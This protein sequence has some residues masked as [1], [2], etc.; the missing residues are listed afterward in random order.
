MCKFKSADAIFEYE[1]DTVKLV[2]GI[3]E[4]SHTEI[5][6]K[7]HIAEVVGNGEPKHT[8]VEYYPT[9]AMDD[10]GDYKFVFDDSRPN[11]WTDEMTESAISQFQSEISKM[12]KNPQ[13]IYGGNLYL[14][15]VTT[16]PKGFN[17]KVGGYLYL[18][19]V[20]TL[21]K[22]NKITADNIYFDGK[23]HGK[24]VNGKFIK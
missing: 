3:M 18:N 5:R 17:P 22:D 8:P 24:I 6:K 10:F 13:W 21:P 14:G 20:T 2:F 9:G 16:L 23:W 1:T 7:N 19:S 11:W 15:S 12:L 4:D